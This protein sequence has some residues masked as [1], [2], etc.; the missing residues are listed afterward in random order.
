ML[1]REDA[2]T[3][4]T[5]A[6]EEHEGM[7]RRLCS[8]TAWVLLPQLQ[9]EEDKTEAIPRI[10]EGSK[11][12]CVCVCVCVCVWNGMRSQKS[13]SSRCDSVRVSKQRLGSHSSLGFG[14]S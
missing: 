2:P 12:V 1:G 7:L 11:S 5:R 10:Y 8:F 14:S 9:L 4:V 6:Q 3:I 13:S